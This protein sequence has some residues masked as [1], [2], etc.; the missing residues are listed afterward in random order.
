MSNIFDDI[1]NNLIIEYPDGGLL[2]SHSGIR[3]VNLDC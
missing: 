2:P 3:G 1:Y